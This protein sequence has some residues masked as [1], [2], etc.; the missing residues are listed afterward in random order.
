MDYRTPP[1]ADQDL[2]AGARWICSDNPQAASR[3]L[4][5]AFW[6][7]VSVSLSL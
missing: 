5:A 6:V 2:V 7:I 1:A 4:D 3:F